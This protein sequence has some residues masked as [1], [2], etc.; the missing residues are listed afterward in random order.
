MATGNKKIAINTIYLYIRMGILM[1]VK[2]YT[3]RVLLQTLGIDNYGAW[4]AVASFIVIF[5]F[6]GSPLVTATQRFLNFEM[7]SGGDKL[8]HIFCTSLIIF[9][10]AAVILV[11][12]LETAGLWF[13]NYKMTYGNASLTQINIVYQFSI[14]TLVLNLI[15]L[16]YEAVIIAYEKMSFY[17]KISIIEGA[18][19]L[20]SVYV[21]KLVGAESRLALYGGLCLLTQSIIYISYRCYCRSNFSCARF[22]VLFDKQLAKSISVFSGWNFFGALSSM[23]AV[24]GVNIIINLFYG[25][26]FNATFGIANQVRAAVGAIVDNL[27]KAS[28]PQIVKSYASDER[29]RVISLVI[30]VGKY[31]FLLVFMIAVPVMINMPYLLHLWLGES[32]PPKSV[33]FC[34]LAIVQLLFVCFSSPMDTAVFATGKIKSYQLTL[35]AIII[36]NLIITYIA[37]LLGYPPVS[38]MYVK[39][40]VEMVVLLTRIIFLKYKIGL[41]LKGYFRQMIIPCVLVIVGSLATLF[42]IT[43]ICAVGYTPLQRLIFTTVSFIV[44]C[45]GFSYFIAL[46]RA[47]RVRIRSLIASKFNKHG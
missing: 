35:S 15:R 45:S 19:L 18:F 37:F 36:F 14:I 5:S 39:V 8:R 21:L 30:N 28:N 46:G 32:L 20:L 24:Q 9:V 16:P 29:D 43:K 25:V 26:V 11:V 10:F 44:I 41:S 27:Q 42:A 22:K 33:D 13:V 38:A 6:I 1:L 31:S 23:A 2:L 7:G 4:I 34:V 47:Q 12:L 40:F 3:S 17:A